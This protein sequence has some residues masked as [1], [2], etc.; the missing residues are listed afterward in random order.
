MHRVEGIAF[1]FGGLLL[2]YEILRQFERRSMA[3]PLVWY[4]M[5][6]IA[7]PVAN[8]AAAR[9][10]AFREH[11]MFVLMVPLLCMALVALCMLSVRACTSSEEPLC[12]APPSSPPRADPLQW[13]R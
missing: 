4:Y 10:L 7:V 12:A 11:T 2:L 5:I 6:A 9:S 3:T 1:Y 8:G 13:L